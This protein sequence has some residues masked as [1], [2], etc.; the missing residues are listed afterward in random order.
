VLRI[1]VT[2]D[3]S[4]DKARRKVS[5]CCLDYGLDR[6]QFSVFSGC[7][8]P[9]HIRALAKALGPFTKTGS[10]LIIQIAA[11]DWDKRIELGESE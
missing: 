10:V 1:L 2:Y 8:K 3:I 7:L 11:D 6:H 9:V 4:D 5:D